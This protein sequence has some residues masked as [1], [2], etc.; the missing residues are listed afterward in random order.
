[1]ALPLSRA[2]SHQHRN[3]DTNIDLRHSR[4]S[5]R[6]LQ[7]LVDTSLNQ[8]VPA[9]LLSLIDQCAILEDQSNLSNE[10]YESVVQDMASLMSS[11]I[12]SF[13]ESFGSEGV[14]NPELL[15]ICEFVLLHFS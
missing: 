9:H 6:E 5:I 10:M 11:T 13:G 2:Q 14:Y 12:A 7:Q 8:L 15:N 3:A 1:M 4:A